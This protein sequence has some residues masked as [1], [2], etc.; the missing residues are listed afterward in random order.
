MSMI[1]PATLA[2]VKSALDAGSLRQAVHAHNVANA[3]TPGY[4][5]FQVQFEQQLDGVRDALR[6]GGLSQLSAGDVPAARVERD[7][8]ANGVSVDAEVAALSRNTLHYQAL[9]D[10]LSRQY[11]LLSLAI[12]EGRN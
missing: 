2:L 8:S 4:Q 12:S 6:Q 1:D 3:S 11:A 9:T 10:A 7:A 5:P